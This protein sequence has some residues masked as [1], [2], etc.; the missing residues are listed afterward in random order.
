MH[1]PLPQPIR[2]KS[3]ETC[4][5]PKRVHSLHDKRSS[6]YW[7]DWRSGSRSALS[8]FVV[9]DSRRVFCSSLMTPIPAR[10]H[11]DLAIRF[12]RQH[13]M[14]NITSLP[15]RTFPYLRTLMFYTGIFFSIWGTGRVWVS[16][17]LQAERVTERT[18]SRTLVCMKR[19]PTYTG[20]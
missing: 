8:C 11:I 4:F 2:L 7:W 17:R 15:V 20:G 12:F 3:L 10:V 6:K 5:P 1:H 16:F 19:Q 13:F 18:C 9:G 14:A